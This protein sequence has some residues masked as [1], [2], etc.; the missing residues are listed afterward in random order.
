M[1]KILLLLLILWGSFSSLAYG[2]E[3]EYQI[4]AAF[5][6]NFVRFIEWP[7]EPTADIVIGILGEDPFG[8]AIETIEGKPA[9]GKTLVIKRFSEL[10]GLENCH[11][12]FISRSEEGQLSFILGKLKNTSVLT[13]GEM[14]QFNQ[15]GGMIQFLIEENKIR[16]SVHL[17]IAKERGLQISSQ[18]LKLAK[19]TY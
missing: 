12:L 14:S 10:K 7:Q 15:K 3:R 6:Y 5:L 19:N 8:S 18:L 16:F 2:E 17:T 1:V 11:I 4:K 9:K 13:V